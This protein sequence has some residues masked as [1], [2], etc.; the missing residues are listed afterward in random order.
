MNRTRERWRLAGEL[1]LY[2]SLVPMHSKKRKG[3][4]RESLVWSSGFDRSG[5]PEGG[6]PNQRCHH[7][8]VRDL[9]LESR[10][11]GGVRALSRGS[12]ANAE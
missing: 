1:D 3:A 2:G 9:K 4:F 5:P 11:H 8:T 12:K 10:G 7:V 6:T